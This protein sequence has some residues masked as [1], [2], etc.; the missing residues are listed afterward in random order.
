MS[1][2]VRASHFS[3]TGDERAAGLFAALFLAN[4]CARLR[5]ARKPDLVRVS[6]GELY[7]MMFLHSGY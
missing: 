2:A 6:G 7:K 3:R 5:S 1:T 4:T